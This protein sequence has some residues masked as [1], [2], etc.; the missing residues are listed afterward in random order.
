MRLGD[1]KVLQVAGKGTVIIR[2]SNGKARLLRN[3]QYVPHLA[4]NLLSVGQL[5]K[6]GYIVIFDNEACQIKE[7]NSGMCV[8]KVQMSKHQMFLLEVDS[9]GS[10]NIVTSG[11]KTSILW[12]QRYGHLHIRALQILN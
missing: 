7:K 11:Q 2:S 6:A 10:V 1:N 8:A 5:L 3:V 9:V 4:H 12:H